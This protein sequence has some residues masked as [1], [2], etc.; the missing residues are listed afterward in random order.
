[1]LIIRTPTDWI[2][3]NTYI[4]HPE[5]TNSVFL[6]Y[7]RVVFYVVAHALTRLQ[8]KMLVLEIA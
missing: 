2:I 4:D 5:G 6:C 7:T 1:M 8:N 3:R